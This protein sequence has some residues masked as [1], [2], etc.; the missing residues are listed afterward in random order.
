MR[1]KDNGKY[2]WRK[3]QYAEAAEQL[4]ENTKSKG[5][6]AATAFT[7]EMLSNL[8]RAMEH[9]DMTEELAEILSTDQI[10]LRYEV[11]REIEIGDE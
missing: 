10:T 6:D 5:I 7:I 4:G 3:E 8:E 11:T 9:E 1:I 2:E